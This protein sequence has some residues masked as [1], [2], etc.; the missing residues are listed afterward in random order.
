MSTFYYRR[1]F[2]IHVLFSTFCDSTFCKSTFCMC[3]VKAH[4][5]ADVLISVPHAPTVGVFAAVAIFA[6]RGGTPCRGYFNFCDSCANHWSVC[7]RS[8]ICIKDRAHRSAD[9]LISL[10]HA[11]TI[12]L[13]T[14]KASLQKGEGTLGCKFIISVPHAHK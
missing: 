2:V 6:K 7:S 10:P 13:L 14:A 1:R 5:A 12:G 11:L 8:N 4:H 9:V 3:T